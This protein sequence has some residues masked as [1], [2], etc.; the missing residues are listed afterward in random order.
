MTIDRSFIVYNCV[1]FLVLEIQATYVL[2]EGSKWIL[3]Y[4]VKTECNFIDL[5]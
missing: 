5:I 1:Q 4:C 3:R 2:R